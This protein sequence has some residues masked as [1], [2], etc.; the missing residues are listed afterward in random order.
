MAQGL[1]PQFVDLYEA[2]NQMTRKKVMQTFEPEPVSLNVDQDMRTSGPSQ[3][4]DQ[5]AANIDEMWS[6]LFGLGSC[7][8]PMGDT[9]LPPSR[10]EPYY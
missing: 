8:G 7:L 10:N 9:D 2:V 1:S 6:M 5:A 4:M 3:S